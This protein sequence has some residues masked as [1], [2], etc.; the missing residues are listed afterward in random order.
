[1]LSVDRWLLSV[2]GG[3]SWEAKQNFC[4]M[5]G[6]MFKFNKTFSIEAEGQYTN[7]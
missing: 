5:G 4:G 2:D 7:E 6:V 3:T 1:M